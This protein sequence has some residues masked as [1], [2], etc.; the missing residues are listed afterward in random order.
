MRPFETTNTEGI[1]ETKQRLSIQ[2]QIHADTVNTA[3]STWHENPKNRAHRAPIFVLGGG[4]GL[5][6]MATVARTAAVAVVNC[7]DQ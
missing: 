5:E 2:E 1:H 6:G 3:S 7:V 4:G